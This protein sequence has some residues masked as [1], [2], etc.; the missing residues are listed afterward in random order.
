MNFSPSVAIAPSILSADFAR[1][2]EE[3]RAV[4]R[5]GAQLLHLDV[6]DGHMVPNLTFGPDVVAAVKRST[7][8]PLDVHLMIEKPERYI[9]HFVD[10][11]ASIVSVHAE[12]CVHLH[13]TLQQIRE[14]GAQAGVA[15]NPATPLS[16]LDYIL[17]DVDMI[18]VMSV[19]PGFGGQKPIPAVREKLAKIRALIDSSGLAEPP[20]LEVDGG[21]KLDN[22]LDFADAD[23]LVSGSGIYGWPEQVEKQP[24]AQLTEAEL[25]ASYGRVIRAMHEKVGAYRTALKA[26]P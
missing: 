4:T 10:A 2:G 7:D 24:K 14:A 8:L 18:L 3:V 11:G 15:L 19:N 20:W 23:V 16:V 22:I 25:A 26:S 6:M 12:V 9:Q 1:L 21:V 13:R 17:S 5:A